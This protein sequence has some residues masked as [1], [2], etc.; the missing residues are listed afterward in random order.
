MLDFAEVVMRLKPSLTHVL[1]DPLA[2]LALVCRTCQLFG[3]A[4][5]MNN[6][7]CSLC[8]NVLDLSF[9]VQLS[10]IDSKSYKDYDLGKKLGDR[11]SPQEFKRSPLVQAEVF[12]TLNRIV[13]FKS[14]SL[15]HFDMSKLL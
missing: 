9:N 4:K 8:D 10:V 14:Q 5:L 13:A 15:D 11:H 2:A 3:P 1:E 7:R 12:E 6:D